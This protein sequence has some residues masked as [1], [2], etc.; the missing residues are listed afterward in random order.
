[1]RLIR[2]S[3]RLHLGEG[4]GSHSKWIGFTLVELLVVAAIIGILAAILLPTLGQVRIKGQLQKARLEMNALVSAITE[5]DSTYSR[6][7]VSE[8]ALKA[9]AAFGEDITYAG[10]IT[11]TAIWISGPSNYRTNNCELMAV[12]LDLELYGDGTPTINEGHVKNP[13]QNKFLELNTR[14]DTNALPGVGIDGIFRDPWGS[15]Y[16]VTVDLNNDGRARDFFYRRATVS[17]NKENGKIG[18]K[19]LVKVTDRNGL[20]FYEASAPVV[21]WSP[22]PDRLLHTEQKANEGWNR[23]NLL[24]WTR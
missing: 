17:E 13:R 5:Y 11:G 2:I 12:L 14:T 7:P 15:P 24:S 18:L 19:N 21:V 23:D 8:D 16:V 1:M 10:V 20:V 6:Y 4:F 9:A 22:G 3:G